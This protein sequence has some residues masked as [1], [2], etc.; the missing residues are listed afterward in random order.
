M[1]RN[2]KKKDSIYTKFHLGIFPAYVEVLIDDDWINHKE[3]KEIMK[4][5][6]TTIQ[7]RDGITIHYL[8]DGEDAFLV[9]FKEQPTVSLIAHECMHLAFYIAEAFD[10]DIIVDHH[11]T[12]AYLIGFL[13]G[14][15]IDILHKNNR[16]YKCIDYDKQ[17]NEKK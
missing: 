13:V 9:A 2:K 12:I 11:E 3:F 15:I 7:A 10:L 17:K 16:N 4:E 14:N 8:D 6:I 5:D 1:G